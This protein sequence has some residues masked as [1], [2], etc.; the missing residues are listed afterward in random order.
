MRTS[1]QHVSIIKSSLTKSSRL[2]W[3]KHCGEWSDVWVSIQ[4]QHQAKHSWKC[5]Y[6]F[7]DKPSLNT[8]ASTASTGD[9]STYFTIEGWCKFRN[10]NCELKLK[11]CSSFHIIHNTNRDQLDL[12]QDTHEHTCPECETVLILN[13]DVV[14]FQWCSTVWILCDW[15]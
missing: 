11:N 2:S 3:D 7:W 12:S 9:T 15:I 6:L 10:L 14:I 8:C 13:F 1:V 4:H 5:H